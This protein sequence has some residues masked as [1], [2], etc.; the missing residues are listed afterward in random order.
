MDLLGNS[1]EHNFRNCSIWLDKA[2]Q[3]F[4]MGKDEEAYEC[5]AKSLDKFLNIQKYNCAGCNK[6]SLKTECL[7]RC[8]HCKISLLQRQLS[9]SFN[10]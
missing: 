2:H 3:H 8:S 7:P 10:G 4:Y 5:L 1:A 9:K 6:K